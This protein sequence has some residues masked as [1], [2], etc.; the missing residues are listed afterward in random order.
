[1]KPYLKHYINHIYSLDVNAQYYNEYR[2]ED[3]LHQFIRRF[4]LFGCKIKKRID[5]TNTWKTEFHETAIPFK[6]DINLYKNYDTCH[7]DYNTNS[8]EEETEDEYATQDF[9]STYVNG[10]NHDRIIRHDTETNEIVSELVANL[11][12]QQIVNFSLT[13]QDVPI[14]TPSVESSLRSSMSIEDEVVVDLHEDGEVDDD[15]DDDD[16]MEGIAE[17]ISELVRQE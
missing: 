16:E 7:L 2:L 15:D 11:N 10:T 14:E 17:L 8:E 1:M 6:C 4:P 5:G 3:K 13:D 9:V 12:Q